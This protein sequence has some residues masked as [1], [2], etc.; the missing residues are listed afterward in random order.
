MDP[1]IT[2][3][4]PVKGL[5]NGIHQFEFQIDRFFF[6]NFENSPIAESD[7]QLKLELDKSSDMYVLQF[8]LE[9]TVRTQCD[10]CAADI[11]LP[12]SDSQR[13][14]VK[15]SLEEQPEE[16]E[17]VYINPE[18]PQLN[19]AKYIY[20]YICLAIP[21]FKVYDC[22]NDNPRPCNEEALRFLNNGGHTEEEAEQE[23][24]EPNPIWDELK[25]LSN[26][27]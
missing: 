23:K 15:F 1:L 5:H 12:V 7:I 18:T 11:D 14:L 21:L 13:L 9:G 27:N 25:K 24:E 16:A 8:D 3:S 4:I 26:D 6:R 19:V 2:Y 22:E 17:V 20:E 10:R